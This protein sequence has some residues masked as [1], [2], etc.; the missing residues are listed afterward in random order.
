MSEFKYA[1]PVC[2]QHMMCDASQGGAVMECPTCFQ[3]IVAP[4][5]PSDP[6]SKF[7]LTG[8]KFTE[9][10]ISQTLINATA[11]SGAPEKS[12]P[13]AIVIVLA[14]VAAAGAGVFV[15]RGKIFKSSSNTATNTLAVANNQKPTPVEKPAPTAPPASDANWALS[16]GTNAIAETTT[17]G[18]IHGQDFLLERAT[19][20]DGSL[21]LRAGTK[22]AVEFGAF[23]NF[24]GAQ[25]ESLAEKTINVMPDAE[26]AARV[27]L[28][29][30][31]AAGDMQ[32]K[33]FTNGYAM[34]LEFG[35]LVNNH[36]P[37]KIY[38]CAPD[39][40]KSYLLGSFNADARKPKPKAPKK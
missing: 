34:R 9:K 31:D 6:D 36:L 13:L 39:A 23:V 5:A 10:K 1:C 11:P 40:E 22:G 12:F 24:A 2:G 35:A 21:M 26:R 25:P 32:R 38:L 29:W 20:R 28:R 3:K 7:I 17:A 37:G 18:R 14:L 8:S 19:F 30:K 27:Q 4:Q 16:L 15:F 33:E